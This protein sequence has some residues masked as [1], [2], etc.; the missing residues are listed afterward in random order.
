MKFL[1][2]ENISPVS[3]SY[4]KGLGFDAIHVREVGLKGK[5]DQAVM[6]YA[7]K[8]G[9]VLLTMDRDFSDVR[10]YP[11]GSHNGVIRMKLGFAS[12][13]AVNTCVELLLRQLSNRDI[14]GNLIITDGLKYR[15]KKKKDEA[16]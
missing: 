11:P 13:Q 1:A 5:S 14:E 6:E 3:V 4:I 15:I 9:R 16:Q 10:N 8:E 12:P 7:L 2:D